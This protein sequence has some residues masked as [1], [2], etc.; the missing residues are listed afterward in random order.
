MNC[1][2]DSSFFLRQLLP[3]SLRTNA[4]QAAA[5][6]AKHLAFVPI[7]SFTRFEVIQALRF[8]AWRNQNDRTKGLPATQVDSALNI[9]I[10]EIGSAYRIVPVNW[11]VAFDRAEIITRNTPQYGWR[12]ADI[13]HVA[14]A[15]VSDAKAFYSYD[16]NQNLLASGEGLKTP[17]LK[18]SA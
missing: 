7:S 4:I 9:F 11:N 17:L 2:C 5:D 3:S 8:E 12:T 18:V 14:C 6:L 16:Y 1:Y 15:L 13:L 10:S